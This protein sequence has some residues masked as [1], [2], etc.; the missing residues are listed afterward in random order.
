ML[1]FLEKKAGTKRGGLFRLFSL[2]EL[3]EGDLENG[4]TA[5]FATLRTGSVGKDRR[6]AFRAG[7]RLSRSHF[8]LTTGP[9]ASVSGV[10][11]LRQC[12]KNLIKTDKNGHD[13]RSKDKVPSFSGLGKRPTPTDFPV[14]PAKTPREGSYPNPGRRI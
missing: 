11:L 5:I 2:R 8:Q 7:L 4:A 12:H 6:R 3:R 13:A 1:V 9:V 14:T 10:S